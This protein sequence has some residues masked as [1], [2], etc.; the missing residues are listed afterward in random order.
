MYPQPP[1]ASPTH[2]RPVSAKL[3]ELVPRGAWR[4]LP[5]AGHPA[6]VAQAR[7]FAGLLNDVL[8]V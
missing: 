1:T 7:A 3:A 2:H 6:H 5:E 4:E 8:E